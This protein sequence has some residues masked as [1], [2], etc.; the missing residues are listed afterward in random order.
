MKA[1]EPV[2][3]LLIDSQYGLIHNVEETPIP[4]GAP[5]VYRFNA[6]WNTLR[7]VDKKSIMPNVSGGAGYSS[8]PARSK[9]AAIGEAVERY[10]AAIWSEHQLVASSWADLE[11]S[12][13]NPQSVTRYLAEQYTQ[14]GFPF[15]PVDIHTQMSWVK[16]QNVPTRKPTL[17]PS[18]LVFLPCFERPVIREQIST[19]LACGP[20]LERAVFSGLCECIERDAFTITWLASLPAPRIPNDEVPDLLEKEDHDWACE[21][22]AVSRHGGLEVTISDITTDLRV[23]TFLVTIINRAQRP[24]MYMATASHIHTGVALRRAMEEG[25]G[26]YLWAS[27]LIRCRKGDPPNLHSIHSIHDRMLFYAYELRLDAVA[28]LLDAPMAVEYPTSYEGHGP[29]LEVLARGLAE[30]G[31]D[32]YFVDLTTSDVRPSGLRVVRVVCPRL[33]YLHHLIPMLWCDRLYEVPVR[34]GYGR[35][36]H[37]NP[38]PHPFP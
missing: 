37:V 38:W 17:V 9:A 5:P 16:G 22:L 28:F 7:T 35:V 19:G 34:M 23:P 8:N 4:P 1:S 31:I 27:D 36:E 29:D 24:H 30:D 13:V 25:L 32:A 2:L 33:A 3:D 20:T 10:C 21:V 12:A 14:P 11:S 18:S 6:H 26:A 15:D